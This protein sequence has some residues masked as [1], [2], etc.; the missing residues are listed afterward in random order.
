M[1]LPG[2]LG[3]GYDS[4]NTALA[5][6]SHWHWLLMLC[7]AKVMATAVSSGMGMPIGNHRAQLSYWRELRWMSRFF[8]VPPGYPSSPPIPGFYALLGMGGVMAALLNAPLAAIIAIL[9]L[10]HTP[11]ALLPGII[12][13]VIA[14]LC[15]DPNLW[16][17]LSHCSGFKRP[18]HKP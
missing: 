16:T 15:S 9:E 12:V 2:V 7:L 13:I 10:A 3:I 18:G 5:G 11:E 6:N 4:V 1:Y 14:T 17:R 8:L